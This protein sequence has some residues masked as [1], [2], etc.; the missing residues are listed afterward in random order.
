MMDHTEA[1]KEY[2]VERYLLGQMSESQQDQF[3]E[4][5]FS[6]AVCAEEVKTGA[7]FVA[8]MKAVFAEMAPV[9]IHPRPER[10]PWWQVLVPRWNLAPIAVAACGVFAAIIGYQNLFQVPA[11]RARLAQSE[12]ALT[13]SPSFRIR[14][15][16][17]GDAISISR[18][19]AAAR[20]EV[21]H[22]WD[23]DYSAYVIE[24]RRQGGPVVSHFNLGATRGNLDITLRP[25]QLDLGKYTVIINGVKEGQSE[26][27]P[28]GRVPI[29]ITE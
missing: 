2:A 12:N 1:E 18:R 23:E 16:R 29:E 4:H 20:F 27:A 10:I 21:T 13:A 28:L 9:P 15:E 17:S 3:E 8:N 26:L 19:N 5:F 11:L 7:A 14:A 6:C 22:D 24:I 25:S